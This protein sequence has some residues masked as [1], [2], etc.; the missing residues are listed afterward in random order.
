MW[1]DKRGGLWW[2]VDVHVIRKDR[3]RTGHNRLNHPPPTHKVWHCTDWRVSPQ[4]ETADNRP[5]TPDMPNVRSYPR[6]HLAITHKLGEETL[7]FTGG[8]SGNGCIHLRDWVGHLNRDERRRKR[9]KRKDLVSEQVVLH[10]KMVVFVRGWFMHNKEETT[11]QHNYGLTRG[12]HFSWGG[13]CEGFH[14]TRIIRKGLSLVKGICDPPARNES[15]CYLF[16]FWVQPL[17]QRGCHVSILAVQLYQ[18]LQSF[19]HQKNTLDT[20]TKSL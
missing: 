15:H 4:H 12:C 1:Y 6:Q 8:S 10:Y 11:F 20:H 13:L 7:R 2:R 9:R 19:L 17:S 3:L 16:T 14:C 18:F 5:H